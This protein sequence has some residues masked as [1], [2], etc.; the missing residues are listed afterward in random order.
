MQGRASLNRVACLYAALGNAAAGDV[1]QAQ[2]D[3]QIQQLNHCFGPA[4]FVFQLA[5]VSR[6]RNAAWWNLDVNSQVRLPLAS[7][8]SCGGLM[9]LK[10]ARCVRGGATGVDGMCCRY[11]VR[12]P[13]R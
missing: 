11:A 6:Y 1:T 9:Q 10:G 8:A 3:A 13:R 4:S 2:I 7:C 5:G 12:P